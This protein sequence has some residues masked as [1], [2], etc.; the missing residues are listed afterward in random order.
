MSFTG[1]GYTPGIFDAVK[2]LGLKL[3]AV[4]GPVDFFVIDRIE[5]PSGN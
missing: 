1:F 2:N 5:R 4:K 3:E